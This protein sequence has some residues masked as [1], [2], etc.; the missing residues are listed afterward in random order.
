MYVAQLEAC[1]VLTPLLLQN[2]N[3]ILFDG[4]ALMK[5]PCRR[6]AYGL[7]LDGTMA[8][9]YFFSRAFVFKS[10]SFDI[11]AVHTCTSPLSSPLTR[12]SGAPHAL[13]VLRGFGERFA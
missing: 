10:R 1:V 8:C 7:T 13:I 11:N 4:L 9:F 5:D 3:K 2:Y 6:F 12:T